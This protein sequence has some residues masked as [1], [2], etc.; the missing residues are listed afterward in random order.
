MPGGGRKT[1]SVNA[2]KRVAR[3]MAQ[4]T[5]TGKLPDELLREW[6][7]SG[8]MTYTDARGR[9]TRV[10][11]DPADRIS[12]AKGCAAYYKAPYQARPAPGEA[13]PVVRVELDEAMVA[14]LAAKSPDKLEVLRDVLKVIAANGVTGPLLDVTPNGRAN[15]SGNGGTDPARYGRLLTASSETE[16]EA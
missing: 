11:L 3:A 5:G 10:E 6:A 13:P 7:D 16:G 4:R 12:C 9:V 1:G 2:Y 8:V 15:G 14:A